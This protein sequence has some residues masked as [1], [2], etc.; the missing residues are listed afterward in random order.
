MNRY[1]YDFSGLETATSHLRQRQDIRTM[2]EIKTELNK[3]K[4]QKL[5]EITDA[6]ITKEFL[7]EEE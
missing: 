7:K 6:L 3:L 4:D 2:N 1:N 5:R